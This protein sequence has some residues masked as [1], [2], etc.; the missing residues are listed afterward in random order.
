MNSGNIE[1][2]KESAKLLLPLKSMKLMTHGSK[3]HT[4][5]FKGS[6]V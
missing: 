2:E 3:T 4:D 5:F 1:Q 6:S